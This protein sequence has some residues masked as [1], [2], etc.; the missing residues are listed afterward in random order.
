MTPKNPFSTFRENLVSQHQQEI[1]YRFTLELGIISALL[2]G[3]V[4]M[5]INT[6]NYNTLFLDEAINVVIG[7]GFL[8]GDFS[9]NAMTFHF[10]SYLYPVLAAF[11]NKAGGVFALRLMSTI[12]ICVATVLV[13]FTT[14]KLFGRRAGLLGILLFLFS[15]TILN[16]SQLAV[17][18]TLAIP[19]LAAS[20]LLLVTAITSADSQKKLLLAASACALLSVLSKY[21]GLLYLPAL[22]LTALLLLLLR[23]MRLTEALRVLTKFFV[24]PLAVGL[25]LYGAY[26]RTELSRVFEEQG[27][28]PASQVQILTYLVREIGPVLLLAMIGVVLLAYSVLRNWNQNSQTA[29]QDSWAGFNWGNL[30]RTSRVLLFILT[31]LM[32][33]AWLASPIQ[34]W[35]TSNS[36]S[37][38]KN[39]AYSLVFLVP[40]AGYLVAAV[41]E[42]LR[43]RGWLA[44]SLGLLSVCAF[45]FYFANHALDSNWTFQ[46]SW[47]NIEGA[48][49]YLRESGLNNDSLV[50]AEDMDVY[51]YYFDS[52]ISNR[53]VWNSFWYMEHEG[54]TGHEGALAAIRDGAPDF[55]IVNDYYFPG[56]RRQIDSLLAD[57]GYVVGWQEAQQLRAGDTIL[58][59]IFIRSEGSPP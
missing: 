11:A 31:L 54:L 52:D 38:W 58:L 56:I 4:I 23:G 15:G 8:Q 13:Y 7:D 51:E 1:P 19:F 18:D 47:P 6:L 36:R 9:R 30:P 12:L 43:S 59:Q 49:A 14:R 35:L 55:I 33:L 41:M 34:Q 27:Y 42:A 32:V 57:A 22:F 46:K 50:I 24:L 25:S 17:Y 40:A 48:V 2:F 39:S 45:F 44:N 5:Q 3:I 37:L 21:I 26:Y 10:G 28:S 29:I 20:Y 16:L 53:R